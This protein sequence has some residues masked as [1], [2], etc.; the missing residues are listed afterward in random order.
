MDNKK[1]SAL[2]EQF[3]NDCTVIEFKYEYPGYADDV[4]FGIITALSEKDMEWK[5][6][7]L[8]NTYRPYILLDPEFGEIRAEFI[9]NQDKHAKRQ[10]R[11]GSVF[12]FDEDT[13]LRHPELAVSCFDENLLIGYELRSA[14]DSLTPIQR[15]SI[16]AYFFLGMTVHEIAEQR[17]VKK[18]TVSRSIKMAKEKIK[19]IL[20]TG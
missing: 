12:G 19:K 2:E 11:H 14:I 17:G 1:N 16:I 6:G 9:Q 20:Q 8:L 15:E 18:Q 3:H 5:Y 10:N 4:P 7:K 13:E